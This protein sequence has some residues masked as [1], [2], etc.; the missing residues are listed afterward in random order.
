MSYAKV[1]RRRQSV[2]DHARLQSH[3]RTTVG[4]CRADVFTDTDKIHRGILPA[5][6]PQNRTTRHAGHAGTVIFRDPLGT[7]TRLA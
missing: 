6:L 7:A 5:P 2:G 4:E 1:C 3:D